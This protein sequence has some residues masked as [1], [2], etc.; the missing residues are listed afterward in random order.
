MMFQPQW[1]ADHS[2]NTKHRTPQPH[3]E[4]EQ[5]RFIFCFL[6]NFRRRL[7]PRSATHDAT[8]MGSRNGLSV[9]KIPPSLRRLESHKVTT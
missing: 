6:K 4:I 5:K 7:E 2:Y 3:L 1:F 8:E 9:T